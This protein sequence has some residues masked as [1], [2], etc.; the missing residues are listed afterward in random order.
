VITCCFRNDNAFV[1]GNVP[2][3]YVRKPG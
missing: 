3:R 2:A 1:S